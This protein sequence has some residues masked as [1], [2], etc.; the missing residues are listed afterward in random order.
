M[1]SSDLTIP[2]SLHLNSIGDAEV[3]MMLSILLIAMIHFSK[4]LPLHMYFSLISKETTLSFGLEICSVR[5][6]EGRIRWRMK[7]YLTTL[8]TLSYIKTRGVWKGVSKPV[9]W[10]P[11]TLLDCITCPSPGRRA[12]LYGDFPNIDIVNSVELAQ[13]VS[14]TPNQRLAWFAVGRIEY[15][16]LFPLSVYLYMGILSCSLQTS[17]TSQEV[18][19][20]QELLHCPRNY[21]T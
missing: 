15:I 13:L 17:S 4:H 16:Y 20:R 6:E 2:V 5:D 18:A 8:F 11:P 3:R 19:Q 12:R 21:Q 7:I 14:A 10:N 9:G 1:C